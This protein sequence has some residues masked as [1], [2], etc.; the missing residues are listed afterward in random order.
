M[1]QGMSTLNVSKTGLKKKKDVWE[2]KKEFGDLA[3]GKVHTKGGKK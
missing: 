1:S 3:P 2:A